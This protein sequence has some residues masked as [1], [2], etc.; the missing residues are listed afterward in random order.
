MPIQGAHSSFGWKAREEDSTHPIRITSKFPFLV[1]NRSNLTRSSSLVGQSGTPC[2]CWAIISRLGTFDKKQGRDAA[3]YQFALKAKRHGIHFKEC[4]EQDSSREAAQSDRV[5]L[6]HPC[7]HKDRDPPA[8]VLD[9]RTDTSRR[10]EGLERGQQRLFMHQGVA[11]AGKQ[12]PHKSTHRRRDPD[13][14]P[15]P[16]AALITRAAEQLHGQP[17]PF[18][19][20]WAEPLRS[21]APQSGCVQ[22][23]EG[24]G[25]QLPR[26]TQI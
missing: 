24:S 2:L 18:A 10:M 6:I 8:S 19:C 26:H 17:G 23:E 11:E 21:P 9:L 3:L 4:E 15:L 5:A 7:T 14:L 12:R 25:I 1:P 16:G 20:G 22:V 13:P